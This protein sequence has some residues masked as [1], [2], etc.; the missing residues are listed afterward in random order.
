LHADRHLS[1]IIELDSST[2]SIPQFPDTAINADKHDKHETAAP[3][4]IK[5]N[6]TAPVPLSV[7]D[8]ENDVSLR[9]ADGCITTTM[10]VHCRCSLYARSLTVTSNALKTPINFDKVTMAGVVAYQNRYDNYMPHN[11]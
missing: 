10:L 7:P 6:A 11:E 8:V 9:I 4:P 1:D 3:A 5:P 2:D